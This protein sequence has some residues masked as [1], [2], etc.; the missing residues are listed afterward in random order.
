MSCH[1][2]NEL[3]ELLSPVWQ[4]Q[5]HLN[6]VEILQ[7][8]TDETG[9]KGSLSEVTDDMLIYHL[10]MRDEKREAMIPGIAK[11]VEVDFKAAILKAR[12]ITN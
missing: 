9:H 7:Q 5:G 11:D 2:I 10:K 12:G 1:R 8:L 3:I 4:Q 6:L